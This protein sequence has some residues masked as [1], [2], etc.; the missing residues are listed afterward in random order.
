MADIHVNQVKFLVSI[1]ALINGRENCKKRAIAAVYD[2]MENER[3]VR[4][5]LN[6]IKKLEKIFLY[7]MVTKIEYK[8]QY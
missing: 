6:N 2:T 5:K 4:I 8:K 1:I 3:I 7:Q